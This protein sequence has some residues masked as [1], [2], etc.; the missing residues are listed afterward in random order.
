[1]LNLSKIYLKVLVLI[2]L[3]FFIVLLVEDYFFMKD[4]YFLTPKNLE[5]FN[6]RFVEFFLINLVVFFIFILLLSFFIRKINFSLEIEVNKI[7]KFLTNLIKHK[8]ENKIESNFSIEFLK[9]TK[10]LTKLSSI[11]QKQEQNYIETIEKLKISNSQK[12]EIISA[13]SHEFKNPISI[14][15]GYSETLLDNEVPSQIRDK[16]LRKIKNNSEK[17]SNLIDILRLAVRLDEKKEELNFQ[18]LNLKE[19]IDEV[20]EDISNIYKREI[21]IEVENKVLI[22]AD[23]LLLS[24][25]LSN[26]IENAIK[27]SDDKILIKI[28]NRYISIIDKGIGIKKDEI[29][30]ITQK[31]YRINSNEWNNSLGLGLYIVMNIIKLHNFKLE[32]ISE[33]KKGSEFRVYFL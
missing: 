18:I 27:Y 4:I 3:L 23:K 25:A 17:L 31:F 33:Y 24:I 30:K 13:I 6:I 21:V 32:I 29:D 5:D 9:I 11:L 12:E 8:K 15:N 10:L 7:L 14:I 28:T 20:V 19:L 1:L 26:L 16:F 2:F 22:K